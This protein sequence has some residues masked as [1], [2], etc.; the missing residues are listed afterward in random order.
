VEIA[1]HIA[2]IRRDGDLLV[3]AARRAGLDAT[4]PTCP[5]WAVRDLVRH[6]GDVHRWATAN[7][8]SNSTDRMSADDSQVVLWSW[9][10]SDDR[11]LDWFRDGHAALISGLESMSDDAVA[12]Q[13]LPA[14]TAR[15]FWARRQAHELAIHRADA[16]SAT[17]PVT[18][19]DALFAC[20]GIDE[21]VRGFGLRTNVS[22][23]PRRSLRVEPADANQTW[24]LQMA[25]DGLSVTESNEPAD[26]TVHGSASDLYLLMWNRRT[27]D[28]LQVA[29][30]VTVLDHWRESMQVRWSQ[31]DRK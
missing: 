8:A 30:D 15:A 26:C 16:E 21:I 19:Y 6:Q 10:E 3:D 25:P 1:E 28:G 2:H 24:L 27:T 22:T 20:D 17:G 12:W 13:F 18:P 7:L 31:R 29:G 4:V 23:D 11:L 5:D 14:P 9:P